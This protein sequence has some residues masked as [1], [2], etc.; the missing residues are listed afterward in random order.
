L[1]ARFLGR[2]LA[3]AAVLVKW[4]NPKS[5]V[6]NPKQIQKAEKGRNPKPSGWVLF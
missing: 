6:R 2:F 1:A 4:I 3:N 5:E